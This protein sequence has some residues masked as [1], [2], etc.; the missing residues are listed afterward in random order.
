MKAVDTPEG[1]GPSIPKH[2]HC[3]NNIIYMEG[4]ETTTVWTPGLFAIEQFSI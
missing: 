3:K 2:D 4:Y 1:P